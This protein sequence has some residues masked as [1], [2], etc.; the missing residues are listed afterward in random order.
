MTS[1]AA[2]RLS[3]HTV[4][5]C[6]AN[7]ADV[8]AGEER[9]IYAFLKYPFKEGEAYYFV[10]G[11]YLGLNQPDYIRN[12]LTQE[13]LDRLFTYKIRTLGSWFIV[14]VRDDIE[15]GRPADPA[16]EQTEDDTWLYA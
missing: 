7:V 16:E 10:G 11:N 6:V 15:L 12:I 9:L 13:E 4:M 3:K 2:I 5:S 8:P 14:K 1:Y